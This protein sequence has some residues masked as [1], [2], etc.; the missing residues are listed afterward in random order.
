MSEKILF[1]DDDPNILAAHQRNFRRKF[2]LDVAL[3]AQEALTLIAAAGREPYAV[4]MA[5][6]RMPGM[7][8]TEFL[9]KVRESSPNTTRM[10][11]TGNIDQP[12]AAEAINR[13]SVYRFLNKPCPAE[14]LELSLDEG[15]RYHRLVIAERQLLEKTLAGSVKVLTD[16]LALVD[17]VSFGVGKRLRDS[18]RAFLGTE[19][20]PDAWALEI[21]ALLS[22]IGCVT[23]PASVT[24]KARKGVPLDHGETEMLARAPGIAHG[25]I[26][27]IPRLEPVAGMILYQ[28][29][30]Y[31]GTGLPHDATAGEAIPYGARLLKI[32]L[33]IIHWEERGASVL[34][35]LLHMQRMPGQFDPGLVEEAQRRLNAPGASIP[36]SA[37]VPNGNGREVKISELMTGQRLVSNIVTSKGLIVVSGGNEIT[38]LFLERIRNF[39]TIERLIEPVMIEASE[40]NAIKSM[41]TEEKVG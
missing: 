17:P 15:L 30:N 19:R 22:Q 10:M 32:L 9:E 16:M 21:A 25:L 18:V 11:L 26:C 24:Q 28:Q 38:P 3:G 20:R 4:V 7:S 23:V 12:T 41:E 29:K 8:G 5:D 14:T 34:E 37:G 6:M 27:N 33:E 39:S 40:V 2:N 35:A 31:D 36:A 1:V 13:G